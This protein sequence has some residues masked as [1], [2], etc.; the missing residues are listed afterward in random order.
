MGVVV[1]EYVSEANLTHELNHGH[2]HL[3]G[4][5]EILKEGKGIKRLDL[6]I[7]KDAYVRQYFFDPMSVKLIP[8]YVTWS[9]K[10]DFSDINETWVK[11]IGAG[12]NHDGIYSK[13][14]YSK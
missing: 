7:E 1:M 5:I 3:T 6:G 9:I 14:P 13:L 11:N 8:S 10:K 12:P 4:E 2:Q